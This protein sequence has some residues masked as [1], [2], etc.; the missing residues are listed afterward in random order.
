MYTMHS[1]CRACG[2]KNLEP[3]LSLGLQP[4]ANDFCRSGEERAGFAPL[5]VLFCP[6][7]TLAQLSVVIRPEILYSNYSYVTSAS[8]MMQ[9][10]FSRL[11]RD[12]QNEGPCSGIVEI[13]SNTGDFLRFA[14]DNGA[15]SVIGIDPAKNL[16]EISRSKG[17]QAIERAFDAST[18]SDANEIIGKVDAVV[19]RHVFCH[20]D[21]WQ[22]FIRNLRTLG[23]SETFYCI[24]VPYAP[25]MLAMNS[26]DQVYHEHLSYLTIKAMIACLRDT[27]LHIH[28]ISRYAIHGGAIVI[29]LRQDDSKITPDV[30][31][32]GHIRQEHMTPESWIGFAGRTEDQ[33]AILF[34]LIEKLLAEDNTVAGFGASAKSTVWI[35]ACKLTKKHIRFLCDSTPQKQGRLSPGSDIPILTESE[36]VSQGPD[37][38]VCFAWNFASEIISKQSEFVSNGGQFIVPVPEVKILQ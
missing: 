14:L 18:A 8:R 16:C 29:T 30:Y 34:E 13:G 22:A 33:R 11:W 19:A 7:C 25:D 37:Y 20:I 15:Q 27:G 35:N 31:A 10:H 4:L 36:L 28:R 38:A 23:H 17:I 1:L 6:I 3:V 24:E 12:M 2:C 32:W 26:F 9:D 21:N 5:E